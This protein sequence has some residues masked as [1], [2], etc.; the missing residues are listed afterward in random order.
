MQRRS[1]RSGHSSSA[2][3]RKRQASQRLRPCC[4]QTPTAG[5]LRLSF[6]PDSR[7]VCMQ[8][9]RMFT[10]MLLACHAH[11]QTWTPAGWTL[12]SIAPLIGR[13]HQRR[14]AAWLPS[15]HLSGG[16]VDGN[17]QNM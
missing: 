15:G 10:C 3:S 9:Q 8:L 14:R 7:S 4:R 16:T 6:V 17:T 1:R 12:S 11:D 13:R 2:G 5:E